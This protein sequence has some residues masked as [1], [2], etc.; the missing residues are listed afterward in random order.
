MFSQVRKSQ[1]YISMLLIACGMAVAPHCSAENF[2]IF[3]TTTQNGTTYGI[4]IDLDSITVHG[5][6]ISYTT[7]GSNFSN[8][9]DREALVANCELRQRGH[10]FDRQPTQQVELY[11]VYPGSIA[12]IE[13][14]IACGVIPPPNLSI[15]DAPNSNRPAPPRAKKVPV[16]QPSPPPQKTV[17]TGSGFL[18]ASGYVVTN[19]HVAGD[20]EEI[21][22]R[23]D[24]NV[25]KGR[26]VISTKIPDLAL[27][28]VKELQRSAP[29]NIRVTALL[30]EDITVAGHPLAGLLADDLV[31]TF[32]QVNAL[33]GLGNDPT[34]LQ[35]SAPVQPGN[36]GGPLVD[37]A[38]NIVGVVVSKLNVTSVEKYTGD[39]SQNINFAIKPEMLRMFL[40]A[41]R[42]SYKTG[43]L[44]K[45]V[46]SVKVSE[47]ARTFTFKVECN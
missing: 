22:I 27:I 41:A 29:P 37:R 26:L 43:A 34:V 4:A 42:V 13:L 7:R 38:G 24:R 39:V 16:V 46:D 10:V 21:L 20:C 3:W 14:D 12:A 11:S 5:D 9:L 8:S 32:G 6:R 1:G 47:A 44:D 17:R 36:S 33:A 28:E 2:S 23:R 35:I 18:V 31:V 30:G 19:D 15:G 40:D 25:Y 45:R